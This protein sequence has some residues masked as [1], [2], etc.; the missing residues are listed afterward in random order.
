VWVG[1]GAGPGNERLAELGAR[2]L[3]ELSSLFRAPPSTQ[4]TPASAEQLPLDL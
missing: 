1:L 4:V 2:P 3:E